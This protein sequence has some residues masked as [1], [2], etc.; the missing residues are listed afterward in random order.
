MS[1]LEKVDMIGRGIRA[2][3]PKRNTLVIAGGLWL[4]GFA[5]QVLRAIRL[6]NRLGPWALVAAGL[7]ILGSVSP[8][9]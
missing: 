3:M 2:R 4:V 6:D 9:L 5:S 1:D 8:A 7:L